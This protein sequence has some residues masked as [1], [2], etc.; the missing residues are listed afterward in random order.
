MTNYWNNIKE[1]II[2]QQNLAS[3]GL[4]NLVG[5]GL[6]AIFWFYLASIINPENYGEIHY[7]LGIAGMAQM[8]SLVTTPKVVTVYTAKNIKIQS[9]LFFLS[10]C[11]GI[12]SSVI[13]FILFETIF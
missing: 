12:I 8:I 10:I 4:A 7:F 5:S 2:G 6:A 11:A 3:I 1:K 9:T 13:V